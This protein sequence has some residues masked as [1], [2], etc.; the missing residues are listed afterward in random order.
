[1]KTISETINAAS[2]KAIKLMSKEYKM[3]NM[4]YIK[5]V[6]I[7]DTFYETK[8]MSKEAAEIAY[9]NLQSQIKEKI[10]IE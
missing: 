6:Y 7:D 10:I 5:I 1:M 8:D 3:N 9:K 4:H 2:V